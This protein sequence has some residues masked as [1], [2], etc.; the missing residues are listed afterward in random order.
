MDITTQNA[1]NAPPSTAAAPSTP[2]QESSRN[3]LNSDFETFL[4]MLTTQM[5]NQDPLNPVE[6]SEFAMQLATFSGVEQQIRTND[7]LQNVATGLGSGGLSQL[8]GWVGMEA[9]VS[10]PASFDG[11]PL[12]LAP[13]AD[14][15]ADAAYLVVKSASGQVVSREELPA[16][17]DTVVWAGV[18]DSGRP[19]PSGQY[20]FEIE[21]VTGGEV[22]STSPVDHYARIRE[23]RQGDGSV[24]IVLDGGAIV[25]SG[26]VRALREP[27]DFGV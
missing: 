27:V 13:E 24:D 16:D 10:A 1:L 15:A 2:E 25:A 5:E 14:P 20:V 12:T 22:A 18:G 19:L 26:D 11:T 8:A 21:N 7:L 23:A 6:S 17:S 4:K 3:A 9:R